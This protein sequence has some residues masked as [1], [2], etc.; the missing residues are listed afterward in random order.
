MVG[1]TEFLA[2]GD[3]VGSAGCERDAKIHHA[4]ALCCGSGEF[5]GFFERCAASLPRA[6]LSDASIASGARGGADDC[7]SFLGT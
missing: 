2:E 5:N 3:A 6:E 7:G 1:V 4:A